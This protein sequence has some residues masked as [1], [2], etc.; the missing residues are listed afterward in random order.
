MSHLNKNAPKE[1]I[2]FCKVH[3]S[4]FTNSHVS[5]LKLLSKEH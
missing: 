3:P 5:K 1:F 4:P 2:V